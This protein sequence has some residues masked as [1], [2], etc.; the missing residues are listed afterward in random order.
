MSLRPCKVTIP[1]IVSP[2]RHIEYGVSILMDIVVRCK[3]DEVLARRG[4]QDTIVHVS[5]VIWTHATGQS[6]AKNSKAVS[7][8]TDSM[9]KEWLHK[10]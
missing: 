2:A 6:S 8:D 7:Q 4:L 9:L 5:L 1:E 3:Q 10:D